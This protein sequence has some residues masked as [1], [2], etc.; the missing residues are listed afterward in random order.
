MHSSLRYLSRTL[1]ARGQLALRVYLAIA[2]LGFD[3]YR[4][5]SQPTLKTLGS[6]ES[7]EASAPLLAG[8]R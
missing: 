2:R 6:R 5:T 3:K 4:S 7:P 8:G 1:P